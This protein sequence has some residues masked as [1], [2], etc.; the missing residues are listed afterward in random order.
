MK[1]W[2]ACLYFLLVP[3]IWNK[4]RLTLRCIIKSLLALSQMYA[5]QLS[6]QVN[7][8]TRR[9][10][11]FIVYLLENILCAKHSVQNHR[12][13]L[14]LSVC[15]SRFYFPSKEATRLVSHLLYLHVAEK[16]DQRDCCYHRLAFLPLHSCWF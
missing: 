1:Y 12:F 5:F 3:K 13:K 6:I 4:M 8:E 15:E 2:K 7:D 11:H 10:L 14:I 16:I 9:V